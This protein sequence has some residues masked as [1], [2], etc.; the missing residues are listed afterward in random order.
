MC[1]PKF[2]V[3]FN[4]NYSKYNPQGAYTRGGGGGGVIHGRN[5]PFQKLVSKCPGTYTRWGLLLDLYSILGYLY[6]LAFILYIYCIYF[7]CM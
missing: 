7:L 1:P 6:L 3:K 5:F 4:F 2:N